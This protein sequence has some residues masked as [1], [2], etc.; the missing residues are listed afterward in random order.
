MSTTE[1]AAADDARLHVVCLGETM[2]QFVPEDDG[3][4]AATS[5]RLEHAGAES[6]VAVGLARLGLRAAWASRLGD[7]AVGERILTALAMEGVDTT[8]VLRDNVHPTGIFLKEPAGHGRTVTYYRRGSAASGM[9]RDDVDRALAAH[10]H[11]LHISG[12][13]SA[14]S[15]PCDDAVEYALGA[16]RRQGITTSFDVNYRPVLWKSRDTAARRLAELAR[17]ADI[18]FVGQDEADELWGT[19]TP[20]AIAAHL[21][22]AGR[23]IVKDSDRF[24]TS[25]AQ[26]TYVSVPALRVEVA[27]AVGAGDAFAAGWLAAMLLGREEAT[28]LRCGHLMARAALTSRT[29][30][31]ERIPLPALLSDAADSSLWRSE[32]PDH[33]TA[34]ADHPIT[35]D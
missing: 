17:L 24:A 14:L 3:I 4:A 13:T 31:G 30:H 11:M 8:L 10:P 29:D 20:D 21:A 23:V 2:G 12:I 33:A 28:R 22:G 6:N 34:S 27:E 19:A 7:D 9:N 25:L 32:H 16:A 18:V 35:K 1:V 5:F 26:G 15:A